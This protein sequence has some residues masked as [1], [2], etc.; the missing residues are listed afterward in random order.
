MKEEKKLY[1]EPE[2]RE[3]GK[4][5]TITQD[6]FDDPLGLDSPDCYGWWD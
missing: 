4:L 2:L 5:T 3:H 1:H 6:A